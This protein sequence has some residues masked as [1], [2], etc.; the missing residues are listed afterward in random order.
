MKPVDSA[1]QEGTTEDARIEQSE[2]DIETFRMRGESMTRI[3][4]FVAAAFAFAVTMMVI[5]VGS[6]PST[7]QEF[8]AATKQI[9][10]F[11]AS[12][13]VIIW[14]WHTHA[15]W[16]RRY[17]LEDGGSIFLSSVLIILVLVYIYPLRLMLQGLFYAVSD[18]YFPSEFSF[19]SFAQVRFMFGFYALGFILL[20]VNFMGLFAYA[21]YK[22]E[23]LNLSPVELFD[24][25]TELLNW[26]G[27]ATV[28][29]VSLIIAIV[30][31]QDM[32]GFSGYVFFSLFPVLH[33]LSYYRSK[34]RKVLISSLLNNMPEPSSEQSE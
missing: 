25:K 27:V 29:F 24:T 28:A 18:G 14:I 13:A 33:G 11:S 16:S 12:C 9:P 3:E 23:L 31:T 17:G 19:N 32:I 10:A 21:S 30:G 6:L 15:N 2:H 7:M 5:S 1:T 34:Q 26:A 20:S 22:K 4:T 8:M